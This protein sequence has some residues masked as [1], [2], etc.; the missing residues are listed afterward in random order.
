MAAPAVA[1]TAGPLPG[2]VVVETGKP[3]TT[4]FKRL[5][6]RIEQN[7]MVVIGIGCP[8]CGAR[9]LGVTMPE[10]RVIMFFNRFFA[11]R[12]HSANQAAGIEAP[13]RMMVYAG[14]DGNAIVHYEK[15]SKIFGAYGNLSLKLVGTHLDQAVEKI[16]NEAIAAS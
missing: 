6:T 8:S 7:R 3:F 4:F 15:P 10:T 14:D 13:I 5:R 11:T 12:V 16:L 2:I 1:Q 9:S